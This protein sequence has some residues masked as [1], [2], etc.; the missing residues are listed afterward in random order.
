M[1]PSFDLL[2]G[3]CSLLE[4]IERR[5]GKAVTD[6]FVPE[7][8]APSCRQSHPKVV[9][10]NRISNKCVVVNSLISP[11]G[12]LWN[13][14][15]ATLS[16]GHNAIYQDSFGNM[17][18]GI[19]EEAAPEIFLSKPKNR[20]RSLRGIPTKSLP[21]E[22]ASKSL[23]LYPWDLVELNAEM[24]NEDFLEIYSK[25]RGAL[26][27]HGTEIRGERVRTS[28]S[29]DVERYVTLDSRSGPIIVEDDAELQ[30]FSRIS[31][32]C[33]I[34]KS[35]RVRSA[36]I[37]EGTSIGSFSKVSGEVEQSMVSEYSNKSHDG[38]IG[39]SIIGSWVNIGAMS[40]NSDL[41]NTYGKI[42]V[43]VNG[44]PVDSG[45]IK[46]GVFIADMAKTAIGSLMT[47][48]RK[49]GVASQVLGMVAEDVPSFTMYG[50]SLGAKSAEIFLESA[51]STQKRMMER[52]GISITDEFVSL[53]RSVFKMTRRERIFQHVTKRKFKLS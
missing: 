13:Y 17:V 53:I 28:E 26:G 39:H 42:S 40:T 48:G 11:R 16:E 22:L 9:V 51:I 46:V 30:S 33:Y 29:A 1:R 4:R 23:V 47:S 41:K 44:K 21:R 49:I 10:N 14:V 45:S 50:K 24:I 31:G 5:T 34:G 25:N 8:L 2:L 43:N 27:L 35:A 32:P 18:F 52:R 3:T 36:R 6:V 15:K 7:Y 19:V 37:R 20:S 12:D 38:F